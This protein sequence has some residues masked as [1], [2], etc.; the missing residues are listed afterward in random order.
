M[1]LYFKLGYKVN[2]NYKS[3][4]SYSNKP[5]IK[6]SIYNSKNNFG[7]Q[8]KSEKLSNDMEKGRKS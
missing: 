3:K 1:R 7:I 6:I 2:S 8:N 4:K 5:I